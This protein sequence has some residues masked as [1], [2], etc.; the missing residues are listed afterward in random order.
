MIFVSGLS[1]PCVLMTL[2]FIFCV[3]LC[4]GVFCCVSF[5]FMIRGSDFTLSMMLL[6]VRF[7]YCALMNDS[8]SLSSCVVNQVCVWF[9]WLIVCK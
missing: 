6:I 7:G 1:L 3:L 8:V 2:M 9:V 4:D 5:F